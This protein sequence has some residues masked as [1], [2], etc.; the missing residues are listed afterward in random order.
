MH[1]GLV[2]V[3][4][5]LAASWHPLAVAWGIVC[6]YLLVAIE[7]TSLLRQ[8]ISQ[9]VWRGIHLTSYVVLVV[10]TVHLLTAGTDSNDRP[11]RDA[12]P[13]AIGVAVVF[14]GAMLLTWRT[15]P[16]VRAYP[17]GVA[18]SRP[19]SLKPVTPGFERTR[20]ERGASERVPF[21]RARRCSGWAT[22]FDVLV[23]GGGIT[24]AGVALDA[25]ARGLR[26]ALVERHDFASGTSSK[27][28]KLV[29][30]G[31]R[32]LQQRE[33]RL[34]YEALY[35]RQRA[36]ENAPHLV[37]VLPFLVPVLQ[38]R[39]R[40]RSTPRAP[41]RQRAVDVRPHR[42]HPDRSSVTTGSRSTTR[43]RTC[44]RSRASVW[45]ARTCLYDAQVDDA[46]L[47]LTIARTAAAHGAAIVNYTA[48]TGVVEGRTTDRRRAR[49]GR[50]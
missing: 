32:Y 14:G 43:S 35:E 1:F 50:R 42:W 18:P 9:K 46:R 3:L 2:D 25:A 47:T 38:R 27:S 5:P 29:H 19:G 33:F 23:V 28:S 24:G 41:A 8:H 13:V 22:T 39:R 21:E 11:A 7:V 48:L 40:D 17:R 45:P 10:T 36:L 6:M 4:V 37:R 15:A 16:K 12:S 49:R 44:R 26:T 31:L 20:L 30:G 34:V